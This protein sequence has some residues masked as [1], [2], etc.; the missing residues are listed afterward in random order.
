MGSALDNVP[1]E[2]Y[3]AVEGVTVVLASAFGFQQ[4]ELNSIIRTKFH[5][6]VVPLRIWRHPAVGGYWLWG[7]RG[8]VPPCP[9]LVIG[10]QDLGGYPT[11]TPTLYPLVYIP[12][13]PSGGE[14]VSPSPAMPTP[15]QGREVTK[16]W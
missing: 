16:C 8:T 12:L 4:L 9:L 15:Y 10:P 5:Q 1:F 2:L 6:K 13:V 14:W 11:P 3:T 7:D